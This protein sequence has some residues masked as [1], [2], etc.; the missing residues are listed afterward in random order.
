MD[1]HLCKLDNSHMQL[2]RGTCPSARESNE[3]ILKID[4]LSNRKII[5][6]ML[7]ELDIGELELTSNSSKTWC[8]IG[9]LL[10][11]KRTWVVD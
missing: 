7:R 4:N 6:D 8:N 2:D 1:Y 3:T 9:L 5:N 11:K 10:T